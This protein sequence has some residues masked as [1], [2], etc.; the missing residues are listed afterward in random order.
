MTF[1]EDLIA[2]LAARLDAAERSRVQIG[3]FSAE[4]P[5]KIGRAHV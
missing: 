1:D 4:H 5:G 2:A 3:H